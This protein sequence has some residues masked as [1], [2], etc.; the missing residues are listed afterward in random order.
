M[1]MLIIFKVVLFSQNIML[2]PDVSGI[3]GEEVTISLHIENNESFIAFQTDI[4]LP[5]SV[6]YIDN[7]AILTDRS[8]DHLLSISQLSNNV[9]RVFTYSFSN[10]PFIGNSGS[11]LDFQVDCGM[12]PG[13][14]ALEIENPIIGN[15]FS[16][17]I[18]TGYS[19]GSLEIIEPE[20]TNEIPLLTGWNWFS[21]NLQ[22]SNMGVNEVLN[23]IGES[24][25]C[26]KNQVHCALYYLGVGWFGTLGVFDNYSMYM[27]NMLE[28]DTLEI[29]GTPVDPV[30]MGYNIFPGWNWIS[31]AP[32]ETEIL[33][34]ALTNLE[35]NA[36]FIKNQTHFATFYPG[37][38]WFGSLGIPCP[39]YAH[40]MPI[41]HQ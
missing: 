39:S 32:Q 14:Y 2:I 36:T 5:N 33:N 41:E 34:Y 1:I 22:N 26:I 17:N 28:E 31:Y 25:N 11:V 12:I 37:S 16:Q 9:L 30:Q 19:N 40:P 10:T 6:V 3:V 18:L 29:T 20:I 4:N 7:S 27:I 35:E 23:S 13:T 8:V 21:F 15:A 24:G 38:G